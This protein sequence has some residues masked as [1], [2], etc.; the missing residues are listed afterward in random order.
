M[1]TDILEG[2]NLIGRRALRSIYILLLTEV[3]TRT[4]LETSDYN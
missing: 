1:E 4:A 3:G 2:I